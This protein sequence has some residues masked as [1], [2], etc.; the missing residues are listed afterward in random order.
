M[1]TTPVI[2]VKEVEKQR[3][4]STSTNCFAAEVAD[5]SRSSM[6]TRAR[7]MRIRQLRLQLEAL[8][9]NTADS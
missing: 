2:S 9:S 5:P 3:L 7:L 1:S 4:H 8:S 6:P